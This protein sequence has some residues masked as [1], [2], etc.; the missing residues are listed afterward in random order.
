MDFIYTDCLHGALKARNAGDL[1]QLA[2]EYQLPR[3]VDICE[4]AI[5]HQAS[6]GDV[7]W[8]LAL[9]SEAHRDSRLQKH[10]LGVA[11]RELEELKRYQEFQ[12]L[13]GDAIAGLSQVIASI[14]VNPEPPVPAG[15]NR[16]SWTEFGRYW[17]WRWM[18]RG[19][20][21]HS[22]KPPR[23]GARP[24]FK[25]RPQTG[26]TTALED[27]EPETRKRQWWGRS[28]V[29]KKATPPAPPEPSGGKGR[30]KQGKGRGQAAK[31]KGS[32]KR[33]AN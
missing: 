5:A 28:V 7:P 23:F 27:K 10:F 21:S 11:A 20:A 22:F 19:D 33:S 9:C 4:A 13:P 26:W 6:L 25:R 1:L 12:A 31:P 30:G 2:K 32:A 24:K 18:V 15:G 29:Q 17:A 16:Q 14:P 3:L 8:I